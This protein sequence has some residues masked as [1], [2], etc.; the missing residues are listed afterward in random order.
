MIVALL[1]LL[2][3]ASCLQADWRVGTIHNHSDLVL[4]SAYYMKGKKPKKI[5]KVSGWLKASHD[6]KGAPIDVHYK[7]AAD[8]SGMSF[9]KTTSGHHIV[10]DSKSAFRVHYPKP[11]DSETTKYV[12]RDSCHPDSDNY[13]ARVFIQKGDQ[14]PHIAVATHAYQKEGD[15]FHLRLLGQKGDYTMYL[16]SQ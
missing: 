9:I 4:D 12:G 14:G 1:S 10:F 5:E 6:K 13:C 2:M 8:A 16:H 7:V 3:I 11:K 15:L